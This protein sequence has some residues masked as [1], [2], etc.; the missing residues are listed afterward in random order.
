VRD[1]CNHT[2]QQTSRGSR[3]GQPKPEAGPACPPPKHT[4]CRAPSSDSS[5]HKVMR[6]LAALFVYCAASILTCPLGSKMLYPPLG[7]HGCDDYVL[8]QGKRSCCCQRSPLSGPPRL[9][10]N[11]P[12]QSTAR[13]HKQSSRDGK[14]QHAL[15]IILSHAGT[16]MWQM[17]DVFCLALRVHYH[18][19]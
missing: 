13:A 9:R 7:T 4:S 15:C 6:R 17:L 10:L 12:G 5:P 8:V 3:P 18:Q 16:V 11:Q 1:T 19:W 2:G 14:W